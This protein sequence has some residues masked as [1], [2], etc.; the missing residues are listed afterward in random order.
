MKFTHTF[1]L[2]ASLAGYCSAATIVQTKTYEFVPNGSDS[3]TFDKFD[4]TLGT[5]DSVTVNVTYTKSGGNFQVDNDSATSGTVNL[6][7]TVVGSLSSSDVSLR[8][9]GGGV[10][11]VGQSGSITAVSSLLNQSVAATTGDS[12]TTFNATGLGDY[13]NFDPTNVIASDSGSIRAVDLGDYQ[14]TGFATYN[15]VFNA[16]QTVEATG[17]SGLQQAFTVS[18]VS[19]NVTV[20]YNYTEVIPEPGSVLLGGLG[21][22]AL[23]RRRR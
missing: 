16:L 10:V 4:T 21:L 6:T 17:L 1:T 23:L 3:L 14:T 8:K 12:N 18:N 20:T 9:T 2:M 19:G 15:I 22:L 5:L 11:S 7:H 13:V